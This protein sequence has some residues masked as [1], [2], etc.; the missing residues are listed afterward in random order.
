MIRFHVVFTVFLTVSSGFPKLKSKDV[1]PVVVIS[2]VPPILVAIIAA[3]AFYL[4]RTKQ[5]SKQPKDWAP[6]RTHYKVGGTLKNIIASSWLLCV[7]TGT[8]FPTT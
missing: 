8:L 4:Y 3:M 5:P 2:L 6:K 7:P 1:I